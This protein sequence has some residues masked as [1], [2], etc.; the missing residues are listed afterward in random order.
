LRKRLDGFARPDLAVVASQNV[1]V[2][3]EQEGESAF[4]V[5]TLHGM[6]WDRTCDEAVS[7][8]DICRQQAKTR[9]VAHRQ[10]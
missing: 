9:S 10:M 7:L 1:F 2:S 8:D 3:F 6:R 4:L 5:N